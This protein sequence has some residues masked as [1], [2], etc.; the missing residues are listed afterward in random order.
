MIVARSLLALVALLALP[1]ARE[2][3]FAAQK[4]PET[5]PW[6][7]NDPEKMARAGLVSHGPIAVGPHGSEAIVK[8]LP[9]GQW[10]FAE[11]AHLRWASALGPMTV[12]LDD[13][14]RVM[15]ELD[16]L[17]LVLPDIPKEPKKLDPWLRLHLLAMKGEDFYA[18]FQRLLQVSD[19][20]FPESRDMDKPFMGNGRFLG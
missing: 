20:D 2:P 9:A 1:H 18:R 8:D 13:K 11:T 6:C 14:K 16:R 7:K 12:E 10:L 17:R 15:A 5:C 19:A 4:K 3:E